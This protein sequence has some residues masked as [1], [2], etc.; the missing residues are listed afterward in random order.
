MIPQEAYDDAG[1]SG[2]D[3]DEQSR[4]SMD[5]VNDGVFGMNTDGGTGRQLDRNALVLVVIVIAAIGGLWSMRTLSPTHAE[6]IQSTELPASVGVEPLQKGLI[7]R[8][9]A[10]V[11]TGRD[12]TIE[13]DPFA[14]WSPAPLRM[15][16]PS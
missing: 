1:E 2:R 10:P 12:F 5:F 9:A 7:R 8:L 4:G 3:F 11:G 13:R 15:K 16:Q 6:G 14:L